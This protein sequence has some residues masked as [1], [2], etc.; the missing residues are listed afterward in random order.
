MEPVTLYELEQKLKTMREQGADNSTP[1]Q[2]TLYLRNSEHTYT[3]D[4][5]QVKCAWRHGRRYVELEGVD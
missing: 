2:I 3:G 5:G 4:V 1:I